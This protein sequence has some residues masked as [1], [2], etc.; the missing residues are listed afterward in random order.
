[1]NHLIKLLVT[2]IGNLIASD[3]HIKKSTKKWTKQI[4]E[5]KFHSN[6]SPFTL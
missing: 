6:I 5:Q 2:M 4:L 3:M 1:M